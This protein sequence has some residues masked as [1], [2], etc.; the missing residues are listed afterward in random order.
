MATG[1]VSLVLM[2][3]TIRNRYRAAMAPQNASQTIVD[4]IR[5]AKIGVITPPNATLAGS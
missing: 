4:I 5:T 2:T 3:H 1:L